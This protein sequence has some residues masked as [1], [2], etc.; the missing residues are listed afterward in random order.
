MEE[1]LQR[2]LAQ[3]QEL[4]LTLLGLEA[5]QQAIEEQMAGISQRMEEDAKSD[6]VIDKLKE[7]IELRE[8]GLA[9]VERQFTQGNGD[10]IAVVKARE[11]VASASAELAKYRR[12]AAREAGGDQLSA[13]NSRLTETEIERAEIAARLEYLTEQAIPEAAS[14]LAKAQEIE[15][16]NRRRSRTVEQIEWELEMAH[17][18]YRETMARQRDIKHQMESYREPSVT[19]IHTN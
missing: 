14:R 11:E 12:T 1:N 4:Q 17:Q 2:L 16:M 13:L 9:E 6:E 3:E 8:A 19:I 5:R 7:V 15:D 10:K 18:E